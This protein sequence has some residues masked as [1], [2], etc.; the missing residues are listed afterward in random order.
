MNTR[1]SLSVNCLCIYV[2]VILLHRGFCW[3]FSTFQGVF[4]DTLW[5]PQRRIHLFNSHRKITESLGLI[6]NLCHAQG[7][8]GWGDGHC[9]RWQ[10]DWEMI[11][12]YLP[13]PL[14]AFTI[15]MLSVSYKIYFD[16]KTCDFAAVFL[17]FW[18]N[19][20]WEDLYSPYNLFIVTKLDYTSDYC[21]IN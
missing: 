5:S 9:Q 16:I 3:H 17:L 21:L 6:D 1:T 19:K 13:S 14:T 12:L 11:T 20:T 18:L 15:Y 7:H 2:C 10:T 8:F 4:S